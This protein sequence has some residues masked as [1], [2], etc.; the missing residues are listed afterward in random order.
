MRLFFFGF[1][2][3]ISFC[4]KPIEIK[5]FSIAQKAEWDNFLEHW[6]GN[7]NGTCLPIMESQIDSGKCTKFDFIADVTIDKNGRISKVKVI[8]SKINCEIISVQNELLDCFTTAIKDDWG[9]AFKKLRGRVI[10][11]AEL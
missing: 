3:Q 7:G 5:K 4:Q 1:V 8:E 2:A 9:T 10:R 6:K 11:G